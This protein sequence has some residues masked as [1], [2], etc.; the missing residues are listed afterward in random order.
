M[1]ESQLS[2]GQKAVGVRFNPSENPW[3]TT[4]KNQ[5]A[6]I[7][8]L[9]HEQREASDNPEVKRQLSIAITDTQTAQMWAVKAMTWQY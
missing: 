3:V 6:A 9:L 4:I 7:I 1:E 5:Y 2:F 8:D